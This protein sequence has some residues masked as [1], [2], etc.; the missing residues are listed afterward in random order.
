MKVLENTWG[1]AP[2]PALKT[3]CQILEKYDEKDIHR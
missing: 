3:L 1:I 2:S